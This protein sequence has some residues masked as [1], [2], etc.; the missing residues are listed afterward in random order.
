VTGTT[1]NCTSTG[2]LNAC[3][4]RRCVATT[5]Q[6]GGTSHPEG[7]AKRQHYTNKLEGEESTHATSL[8]RKLNCRKSSERRV[9]KR[10]SASSEL[11]KDVLPTIH[12]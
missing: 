4:R 9:L 5:Q 10:K 3:S 12:H 6:A 7:K 1:S 11:L 2:T 8:A